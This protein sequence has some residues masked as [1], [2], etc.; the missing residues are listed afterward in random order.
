MHQHPA[1]TSALIQ[2]TAAGADTKEVHVWVQ[3]QWQLHELVA[4]RLDLKHF[5]C[6]VHIARQHDLAASRPDLQQH[7]PLV[8]QSRV[9]IA[10]LVA[11][12]PSVFH[13][14]WKPRQR[15]L[16]GPHPKF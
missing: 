6:S 16:C 2:L 4:A 8:F 13:I 11:S 15:L 7:M 12:Q 5:R 9:N 3:A 14:V 1:I 10:R